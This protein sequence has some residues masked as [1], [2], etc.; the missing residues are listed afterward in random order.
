MNETQHFTILYS[1]LEYVQPSSVIFRLSHDLENRSL[2]P[3]TTV[4]NPVLSN[5]L[6]AAFHHFVPAIE[7]F[8]S[9]TLGRSQVFGDNSWYDKD[10]DTL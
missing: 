1:R 7:N 9:G 6:N 5:E 2:S 8:A 10:G 4:N 3:E